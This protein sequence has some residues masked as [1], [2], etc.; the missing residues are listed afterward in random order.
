MLQYDLTEPMK[1]F[2]YST[3]LPVWLLKNGEAESSLPERAETA[4]RIV[5]GREG[6]HVRYDPHAYGTVQYLSSGYGELFAVLVLDDTFVAAAGPLL[7]EPMHSGAVANMVRAQRLPVRL[8][9][10]LEAYFGGV[11]RVSA[12]TYYYCGKVLSALFARG[13]A[14]PK[15]GPRPAARGDGFTRDYFRNTLRNRETMFTHPPFFLEQKLSG[16]IGIG[17]LDGALDTLREIN[18]LSRA[19]LAKDPLRSLKDSIICSCAFFTRAAIAAGVFPDTAFTA[20]D[21]FI[22]KIEEMNG[23]AQVRG[24]EEEMLREFVRLTKERASAKY[25]RPVFDAL[26]YIDNNLTEDL[27]LAGVAKHAFVHP[28]Y[29]SSLFKKEV[30]VP[31]AEYIARRRVEES[32]YFVAC[33]DDEIADIANFYHFCSQSYYGTVFKKVLSVSPREYRRSARSQK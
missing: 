3:R 8:K 32:S 31:M 29:L 12:Q 24:Y 17:D 13:A 14:A 19:V 9:A 10:R 7:T 27:K 25:S 26:Q 21:T 20:S 30:G 23:T 33:T 18:L 16:Q 22:Q 4:G 28:N 1:V 5:T 6:P 11:E 2:Y 15:A